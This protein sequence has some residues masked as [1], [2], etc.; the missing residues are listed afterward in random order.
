[1]IMVNIGTAAVM[2]S[3]LAGLAV[4][5]TVTGVITGDS[6]SAGAELTGMSE[7]AFQETPRTVSE[8]LDSES[9][10]TTV[11]TAFGTATFNTTPE[12]FRAQ[13]ETPQHHLVVERTAGLRD[14]AFESRDADISIQES[15]ESVETDC[16]TPQGSVS[17]VT[18]NGDVTEEFSGTN[19]QAVESTCEEA[20]QT[21]ELKLNKI[22]SMSV[23]LGLKRPEIEIVTVNASK[24]S[25]LINNSGVTAVDMDGWTLS[26]ESGNE[27]TGFSGVDLGPGETVTVYSY[28]TLE[29]GDCEASEGPEYE[30]CWDSQYVWD[31]DGD[32][33]TL[34]NSQGELI[35]A[36]TYN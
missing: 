32:T 36:L 33:A 29:D 19:Q 9:M 20:E 10:S 27:F 14:I 7:E 25:V 15:S 11:E 2:G 34:A 1:M 31:Q 13:L 12:T 8:Q 16:S 22:R 17:T 30:R 18:E 35:D 28:D 26:D 23:D 24:E 6:V 3:I 5:P 4:I 21:M